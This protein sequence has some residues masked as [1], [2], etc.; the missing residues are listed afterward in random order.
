MMACSDH[1]VRVR[2][3]FF[4]RLFVALLVVLLVATAVPAVSAVLVPSG[5]ASAATWSPAGDLALPRVGAVSALLADG[6]VLVAGGNTNVGNGYDTK[7]AELYDLGTNSWSST[8]STTNGRSEHTGIGL[9]D[10]RVVVVGGENANICTNDVTTEVYDPNT[11]TWSFTGNAGFASA[12][13]RATLLDDGRVLHTGGGNRCGSVYSSAELYD[14]GTGTWSPTASMTV[15]RQWHSAVRLGDGRILVAGGQT[16]G[17]FQTVATAEIYDP[18]AGTWTPTGSMTTARCC[19]GNSFLTLLADGRVLAAGA[20]SGSANFIVPNGPAAEI[21]DPATGVWSPTGP[22][23]SG[24]GGASYSLLADGRVLAAG[25][26]SGTAVYLASA[27]LWDPATGTWSPTASLASARA[28]HAAAVLAGGQVLVASGYAGSYITSAE[29][30]AIDDTAPTIT[31]TTPADGASY[32]LGS[33]V[34]ADYTCEDE[35]GGSGLA[36]CVGTVA[37]GAPIDT[38]TVGPKAFTV[39]TADN[40]GNTDS[41]THNYSTVFDFSGFFSPVDNPPVLN[42]VKAGQAIPV[43]FGL[44]GDHGLDILA[45]GYPKSEPIGCNS[46]AEV[47]GIESTVTGGSSGLTYDPASQRYTYVWKTLKGWTGTCRQLVVKL[48]DGTSH[49]ANFLFK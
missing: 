5:V 35:T 47:D 42:S 7:L 4:P 37:D 18:D 9:A 10:G 41:L 2:R 13:A 27:E 46:T 1:P 15:G 3:G 19:G 12:G 38:A 43:T 45:A 22:M 24:R 32:I 36:S 39:D 31:I 8:G 48:S 49:R 44:G 11:G 16:P 40:A 21:Y 23:S 28:F 25:G 14:T 17:G 34:L 26:E 30:F 6:R 29:I 20:Y 33:T